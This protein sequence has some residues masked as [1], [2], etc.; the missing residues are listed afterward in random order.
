M[1]KG[2]ILLP[3]SIGHFGTIYHVQ[4]V[5]MLLSYQFPYRGVDV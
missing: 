1:I 4:V 3:A 2:K 5:G